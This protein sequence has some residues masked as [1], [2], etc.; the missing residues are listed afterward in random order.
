MESSFARCLSSLLIA[1]FLLVGCLSSEPAPSIG[2]VAVI[3]LDAVA[4][5]IGRD[6][7]IS[8]RVEEYAKDQEQRL[9]TLRAEFQRLLGE[10]KEK[11]SESSSDEDRQA[12]SRLAGESENRLRREI[13]EVQKSAEELAVS[14]VMDFKQEVLPVARRVA[15]GKNMHVVM[16]KQNAMLYVD[17]SVEITNDVIDF[18]QTSRSTE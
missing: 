14:L 7:L 18:M 10:Q 6:K 11:L 16:I 1:P 15:Q 12:F 5:A 3:D 4:A 13:G 17:P 9:N 8:K 2:N